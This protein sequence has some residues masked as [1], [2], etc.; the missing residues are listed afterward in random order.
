MDMLDMVIVMVLVHDFHAFP[1]VRAWTIAFQV[2]WSWAKLAQ[3][4]DTFFAERA[5]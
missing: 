5:A 3:R 4:D 2:L 1:E